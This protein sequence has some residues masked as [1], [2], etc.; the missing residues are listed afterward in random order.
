[1]IS[2]NFGVKSSIQEK[3]LLRQVG[4]DSKREKVNLWLKIKDLIGHHEFRMPNRVVDIKCSNIWLQ[5]FELA[6]SN[7]NQGP[8]R[9]VKLK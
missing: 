8:W 7:P 9:F 6:L 3:V 5:I 2:M 4:H 1:M